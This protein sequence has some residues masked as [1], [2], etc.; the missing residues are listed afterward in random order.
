ME[1]PQMAG[2]R[3]SPVSGLAKLL[4]TYTANEKLK[5]ADTEE[6]QYQSDYLSDLG[7]L[8]RN[9]G[10]T[11]PATEAIPEQG[12]NPAV[13]AMPASPLL[14]PDLLSG[15]NA[16]NYIKT[17]AGKMALAQYLMQQQ[18]QQQA[19]AQAELAASR[20]LHAFNPEQNVGTFS[21]N[22]FN[23]IIQGKPKEQNV[24]GI[25]SPADFT[26]E[27]LAKYAISKNYADL[28]R[29]PKEVN[30]PAAAQNYE[31]YVKQETDAG[32]K[33][34]SFKD[35]ELL[36]VRE[37]RA[38]APPRERMVF[39]ANRGGT[40]NLDTGEFKPVQQG[41]VDIGVKPKDLKPVPPTINTAMTQN[42]V[43]LNKIARAEDLL[44]K[45][46]EATGMFKGMMPDAILNRTDKEG[47]AT[48]AAL[49]ELAA[50]KVHDLSGAAVSV[51]EFGRLKPFLPQ[52][53]DNA[54]TLR[55][56]L[57]GMKAEVEDI[58]NATNQIYS[59]EQ[60]Y[61]PIP[62]LAPKLAASADAPPVTA[63]KEGQTTTFA[64]GQQWTLQ[65]GKQV[66]VK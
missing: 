40:V 32:R 59:E 23:T 62:S 27:S 42:Q 60:G 1:M 36:K 52:P 15:N 21:G 4:Q 12:G 47:T 51:S 54:D 14:S 39:D 9:A 24:I 38:Q 61:K 48:R 57:A 2:V 20:Q 3:V 49:A 63:L 13:S 19:A 53:T 66:R 64:N 6:K 18:A 41:G 30:A 26:P 16:N 34:L 25:P 55:T 33:P 29:N 37:G 44:T 22:K 10:K 35:F 65:K 45:T 56:K 11:T 58:V 31:Y 50:T 43:V 28:L 46:P 5:K 17:G 7:F 8:M